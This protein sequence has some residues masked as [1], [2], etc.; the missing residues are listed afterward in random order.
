MTRAP[1][2]NP[3]PPKADLENILI[4]DGVQELANRQKLEVFERTQ[5]LKIPEVLT[6][7]R[8]ANL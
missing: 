8:R 4:L 3:T 2:P 7:A 5:G 6:F 1:L